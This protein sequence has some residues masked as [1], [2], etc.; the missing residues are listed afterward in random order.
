MQMVPSE[1]ASTIA[2]L[3]IRSRRATDIVPSS[4]GDEPVGGWFRSSSTHA[5]RAHRQQRALGAAATD[6]RYGHLGRR[7]AGDRVG[8]VAMPG[9]GQ[10]T[11]RTNDR[12]Q[13][14]AA[15]TRGLGARLPRRQVDRQQSAAAGV[16][17]SRSLVRRPSSRIGRPD[18]TPDSVRWS[19]D[20]CDE[21]L[22]S[23]LGRHAV[24]R[25][26]EP[27]RALRAGVRRSRSPT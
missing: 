18:R 3:A 22:H 2:F 16:F 1:D 21:I 27:R 20:F 26:R 19:M 10:A 12:F 17:D 23:A 8:D 11:C 6:D 13:P 7:G 15:S 5:E 25:R 14:G 4:V 9:S 24:A